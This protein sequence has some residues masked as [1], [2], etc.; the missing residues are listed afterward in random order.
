MS[1]LA[2]TPKSAAVQGAVAGER[3]GAAPGTTLGGL[4]TAE[5]VS[6]QLAA[7]Q[8]RMKFWPAVGF[9]FG[10]VLSNAGTWIGGFL[11]TVITLGTVGSFMAFVA[12]VLTHNPFRDG[13]EYGENMGAAFGAGM[14]WLGDQMWFT[15][16]ALAVYFAV[17]VAL[18]H[19]AL[20]EVDS[21]RARL[22]DFG[23]GVPWIRG[24]TAYVAVNYV[25]Y[26][27]L[28]SGAG[29]FYDI[30]WDSWGHVP[31][32]LFATVCILAGGALFPCTVFI[33]WYAVAGETLTDSVRFGIQAGIRHW[34][35]LFFLP[36]LV[37]PLFA[38]LTFG[39]LFLALIV[40]LPAF[41]L[42]GAYL[43]RG[44]TEEE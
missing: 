21:G 28:P 41:Y 18:M 14:D 43:F 26:L 4:G 25:C 6:S 27:I 37:I 19:L 17:L 10:R 42:L 5:P 9:S 33:P 12:G 16:M 44:V 30:L 23:T 35:K 31:A 11:L 29:A 36:L 3:L 8:P 7:P 32:K 1:E 38:V 39:T 24:I 20:R 34:L 2:S 15:W 13:G 22:R 40:E